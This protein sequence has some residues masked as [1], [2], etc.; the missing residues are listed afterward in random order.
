MDN[1]KYFERREQSVIKTLEGECVGSFSDLQQA[2]IHIV[3]R[4]VQRIR[5]FPLSLSHE[6]PAEPLYK[7]YHK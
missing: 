7:V 3:E 6:S 1:D 4:P 5:Y 2:A